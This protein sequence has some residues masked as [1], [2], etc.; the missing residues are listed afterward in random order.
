MRYIDV[1]ELDLESRR[2]VGGILSVNR[3]VM[4]MPRLFADRAFRLV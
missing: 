4:K 3:D 1:I 2:Y